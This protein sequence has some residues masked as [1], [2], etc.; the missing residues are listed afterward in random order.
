MVMNEPLEDLN[1]Q[2]GMDS[3]G[4]NLFMQLLRVDTVFMAVS[5]DS[6]KGIQKFVPL[7]KL[8]NMRIHP[9]KHNLISNDTLTG[10]FLLLPIM[11]ITTKHNGINLYLV[12]F[13]L[14]LRKDF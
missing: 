11:V 6:P 4:E 12:C 8:F 5:Q 10:G 3:V 9:S 13:I 1:N 7:F 14:V 2:A